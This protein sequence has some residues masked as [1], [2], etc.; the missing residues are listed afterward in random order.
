MAKGAALRVGDIPRLPFALLAL[1]GIAG[2]TSALSP[3]VY[4]RQSMALH[5]GRPTSKIIENALWET[6]G[7]MLK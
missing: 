6:D 2:F 3:T 4:L 1:A 5:F 7:A